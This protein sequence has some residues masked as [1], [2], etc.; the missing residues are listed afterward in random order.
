MARLLVDNQYL[1]KQIEEHKQTKTSTSKGF[2][3]IL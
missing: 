1:E 2:G 3:L